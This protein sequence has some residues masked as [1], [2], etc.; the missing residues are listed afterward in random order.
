MNH[1]KELRVRASM[2]CSGTALAALGIMSL[3]S[4]ARIAYA[5]DAPTENI[6][7]NFAPATGQHPTG[8]IRD[9]AGNLYVATQEGGSNE[10]CG[11]GCGNILMLSPPG[12]VKE[13]YAFTPTIDNESPAPSGLTRDAKGNLYGDTYAGGHYERGSVFIVATSGAEKTLHNFDPTSGDGYH[14]DGGVTL[15]S[16]GNLYG[17][18]SVGGGT[19]CEGD[20]CGIIYELTHSGSETI[21]YSFT[22][23]AEGWAP[24]VS[25]VIDA[26][27]NLYGTAELGGNLTCPQGEGEG[28]GVVWELNTAGNFTVLYSFSGGTDGAFPE[29]GL[30]MDPLGNLYGTATE[31]GDLSCGVVYGCGVVFEI[32]TS[33]NFTVFHTFLGGSNDGQDPLGTLLRDS[34]GNLYGTTQYGG[35]LSC[36]LGDGFGCGAVFK[37]SASGNETILHAFAGGTTDG[38]FPG[39][40]AL[41]SD[42]KGNLY[43]TTAT[44][45]LTNGG[46]VFAVRAY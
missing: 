15:D 44:G 26:A 29:T 32:D 38:L 16:E 9:A 11:G 22:G 27:G 7:Y 23:G 41:I 34:A 30:I 10:S 24:G 45:G 4:A 33:D 36:S 5:Q 2:M 21:L 20:G 12:R 37:L 13:L 3:V 8:A 35:D 14:P 25:P 6:V 39:G 43:G 19:G 40:S 31:G 28:C 42:G 17:T 18:T 46:V 1:N